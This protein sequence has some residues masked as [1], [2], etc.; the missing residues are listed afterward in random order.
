MGDLRRNIAKLLQEHGKKGIMI[1]CRTRTGKQTWEYRTTR[2]NMRFKI[3]N[4][5][6]EAIANIENFAGNLKQIDQY[7]KGEQRHA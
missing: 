2:G 3:G 6:E 5:L 4:T 1:H 7:M